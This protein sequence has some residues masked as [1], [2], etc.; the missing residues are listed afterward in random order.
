MRQQIVVYTSTIPFNVVPYI[1][2]LPIPGNKL[3]KQ[4][5]LTFWN[6]SGIGTLFGKIAVS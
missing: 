3:Y 2:T 6:F 4:I 5:R 1:S